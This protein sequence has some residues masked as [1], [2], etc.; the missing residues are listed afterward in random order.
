MRPD[1]HRWL[2]ASY[3]TH[4]T[5]NRLLEVDQMSYLVEITTAQIDTKRLKETIMCN[6]KFVLWSH[7]EAKWL[8]RPWSHLASQFVAKVG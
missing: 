2:V 6:D 8:H 3:H 7:R 1:V 5:R 4:T